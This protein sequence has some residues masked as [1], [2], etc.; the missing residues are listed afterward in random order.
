MGKTN[1]RYLAHFVIETQSGLK[2]A[3]GSEGKLV[4]QTIAKDSNGL[5]YIPGT[6]LTG[7]MRHLLESESVPTNT[8]FGNGDLNE[9]VG[10]RIIISDANLCNPIG[11]GVL[12]G[13]QNIDFSNE[14]FSRFNNLP[15]RDHVRINSKGAAD[16]INNG[17][18]DE[19]IVP[20]GVRFAFEIE[21]IGSDKD[22]DFW[23]I[24]VNLIASPQFRI[25]G[26]TRNGLGVVKT[27]SCN[28]KIIDLEKELETYLNITSELD[29]DVSSWDLVN[30]QNIATQNYKNY[31]I[32]IEP[33]SMFMFGGGFGDFDADK[34]PK[35]EQYFSW[36]SGL[37]L[38]QEAYLIPATSIKGALSH[39]V[40]FHYNRLTNVNLSNNE[41]ELNSYVVKDELD[42]DLLLK[43]VED[44]TLEIENV[45]TN[46]LEAT[47]ELKIR[48]EVMQR[49][50]LRKSKLLTSYDKEISELQSWTIYKEQLDLTILKME[51]VGINTGELNKAVQELFGYSK[52]NEVPGKR[53]AVLIS[54]IYLDK[55]EYDVSEKVV[56]HVKIDRFTGAAINGALFNEK[57]LTSH[58]FELNVLV[59]EKVLQDEV[60]KNAFEAAL[61]DLVSGQ[62][63]LGGNTTKG[64]GAFVGNYKIMNQ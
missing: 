16:T 45:L 20:K 7:V 37:P 58:G 38:L 54:D 18:F 3:T 39:R 27:I 11:Q 23:N 55:H 17:K 22:I 40:A 56:Q 33:E 42:Q 63:Q 59:E 9:G 12:E 34:T 47:Q 14:Y 25:G 57:V 32:Q 35:I 29:K 41:L 10:S 8:I 52:D 13:I 53:G 43:E 5:P 2:I 49:E 19:E 4:D 1:K 61:D 48:L 15:Q 31:S 50:L 60:I 51:G 36:V 21:L 46:E 44:F 62:L 28:S 30:I 6:S 26:S 64:H 24:L